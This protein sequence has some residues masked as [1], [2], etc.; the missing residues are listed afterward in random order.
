MNSK[1]IA[2]APNPD[3]GLFELVLVVELRLMCSACNAES[4]VPA[5][6]RPEDRIPYGAEVKDFACP[7]CGIGDLRVIPASDEAEMRETVEKMLLEMI[8]QSDGL[9]FRPC[10]GCGIQVHDNAFATC[11]PSCGQILRCLVCG[12]P[13]LGSPP[14][15]Y[16]PITRR[17]RPPRRGAE[18][19]FCG[20]LPSFYLE[21]GEDTYGA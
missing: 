16:C 6:K 8:G 9:E 1:G 20:P 10:P 5:I 13:L 18:G 7:E 12:A 4:Y 15:M 21:N 19:G 14:L 2:I 3:T 17:A 11:C